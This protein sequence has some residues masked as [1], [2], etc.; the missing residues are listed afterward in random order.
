MN[1]SI[2]GGNGFIGKNLAL[3]LAQNGYTVR[4][5]SRQRHLTLHSNIHVIH[6]DLTRNGS[7]LEKFI[8]DSTIFFNCAGETSDIF[9][10]DAVNNYAVKNL[11]ALLK[12]RD[13]R[14]HWIQLS[15]VGVYGPPLP[16]PSSE[17]IITELSPVN[18]VGIYE[19]SKYEADKFLVECSNQGW[20]DYTILRP[21]NVIGPGMKSSSIN[22]LIMSILNRNFFYIGKQ[23]SIATYVHVDDV[24]S[25]LIQSSLN[26]CAINKI[27]NLSFDCLFDEL[28]VKI[29]HCLEVRS[30]FLRMPEFLIRYFIK[31]LPKKINFPLTISRLNSLVNRT[32][33]SSNKIISELDYE[34]IREFPNS[35]ED[36]VDFYFKSKVAD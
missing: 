10:M 36:L 15:S 24:V 33:Y 11:L 14:I 26:S 7:H 12:L 32:S 20:I 1:I 19:R 28:V 8:G 4:L 17:R 9:R 16:Y 34:F 35:I 31:L 27:Y 25:A 30:P 3:K 5:L 6:G 21:S 2:A 13:K 18:P 22:A 29:A 23:G